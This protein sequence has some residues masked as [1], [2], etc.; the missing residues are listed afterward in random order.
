LVRMEEG[1]KLAILAPV[2]ADE[3]SSAPAETK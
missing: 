1:D 3:E 2:V